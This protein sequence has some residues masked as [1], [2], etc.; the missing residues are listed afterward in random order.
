MKLFK[1][2]A[3]DTIVEVLIAMAVASSVMGGAF[4]VV[5]RT[6]A[7]TRQAQE[8]SEALQL[9]NGQIERII[10]LATVNAAAV[11]S[12]APRYMCADQTDGHLITQPTLTATE[13]ITAGDSSYANDC[14]GIG[15]VQYRIAFKYDLPNDFFKVYITWPSATGNGYDQVNLSYRTY[16]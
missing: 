4:V 6:M 13:P 5:N 1:A 14:K 9:A 8:H 2:T 15:S 3:G 16:Q 7:N 11:K 12:Q 10:K